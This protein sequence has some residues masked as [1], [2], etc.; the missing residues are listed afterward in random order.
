[1]LTIE[2]PTICTCVYANCMHVS[3]HACLQP[4]VG[5]HK[6]DLSVATCC[7]VLVLKLQVRGFESAGETSGS[8]QDVC[9][10]SKIQIEEVCNLV[11]ASHDSRSSCIVRE[12]VSIHQRLTSASTVNN[13]ATVLVEHPKKQSQAQVNLFG[14]A[15]DKL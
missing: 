11:M 13:S 9:E 10:F 8:I 5:H 7:F 3:T 12:S 1:M 6:C 14:D 15:S 4:C 2:A